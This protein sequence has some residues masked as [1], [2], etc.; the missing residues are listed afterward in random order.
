MSNDIGRELGWNDS[1]ENDSS[2]VLLPAGEYDFVVKLFERG[3]HAG[4]EKLPPCN[5]AIITLEFD[6]GEH[7]AATIK[8]NLF[9]HSNTEGMLCSFFRAIGA[10]KSGERLVMDWNKVVGA[11]GRARLKI[12]PGF[13]NPELK[14]NEVDRFLD[15]VT[16]AGGGFTPGQF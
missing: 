5:K 13:K 8:H 16:P 6:G 1:I 12:K 7:G 9:L 2:F 10:R 3:R 15:P 4:S 11:R 14:F